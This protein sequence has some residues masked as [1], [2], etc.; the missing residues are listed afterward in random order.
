MVCCREIRLVLE[1]LDTMDRRT[2]RPC[3]LYGLEL[4][5]IGLE[6]DRSDKFSQRDVANVITLNLPLHFSLS[7]FFHPC[8]IAFCSVIGRSSVPEK[9]P[10]RET[11]E[12]RSNGVIVWHLEKQP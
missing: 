4:S 12:T 6:H 10:G 2:D 9:Y 8:L 7:V 1:V 11:E 3:D 5:I